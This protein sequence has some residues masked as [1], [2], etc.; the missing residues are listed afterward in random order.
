MRLSRKAHTEAGRLMS[1]IDESVRKVAAKLAEDRGAE[2]AEPLDIKEAFR[3]LIL[4]YAKE[5]EKKGLARYADDGVRLL[6]ECGQVKCETKGCNVYHNPEWSDGTPR[7]GCSGPGEE[8][9]HEA[10][11]AR[12]HVEPKKT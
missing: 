10:E 12:K 3:L 9:G 1:Q 2:F 5:F 8:P 6:D 4:Q 11:N 7:Y